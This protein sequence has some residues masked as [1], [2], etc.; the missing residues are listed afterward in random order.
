M[1]EPLLDDARVHAVATL[2]DWHRAGLPVQ[3]R[4]GA[5]SAYFGHVNPSHTYWYFQAVPDL[6]T[7]LGQRTEDAGSHP[8]EVTS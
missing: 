1:A 5:L 3:P 4:P 8:L 7:V 6:M 2:R